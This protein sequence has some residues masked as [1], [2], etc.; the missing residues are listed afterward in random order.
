MLPIESLTCY[1]TQYYWR[2]QIFCL[3]SEQ[4]FVYLEVGMHLLSLFFFK[5]HCP[6]SA[7]F[8][9]S[10]LILAD[11]WS[12][13]SGRLSLS[14]CGVGWWDAGLP[15]AP[16]WCWPGQEQCDPLCSNSRT[17][18]WWPCNSAARRGAPLPPVSTRLVA[19]VQVVIPCNPYVF[20]FSWMASGGVD[21]HA[22]FV[23]LVM[24][25]WKYL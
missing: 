22:G 7:T 4:P 19:R 12:L 5:L 10:V 18:F 20:S 15:P 2:D 6:S 9:S 16:R 17:A 3:S 1:P 23:Q 13:S 24:Y 14:P 8:F 21:L 25:G 11:F